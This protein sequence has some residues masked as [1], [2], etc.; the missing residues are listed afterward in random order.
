MELFEKRGVMVHING[1]KLRLDKSDI[2][3]WQLNLQ[4]SLAPEDVHSCHEA[5]ISNYQQI[6]ARQN[7]VDEIAMNLNVS[8][9]IIEFFGLSDHKAPTVRLGKCVISDMKMKHDTGL[10]ILEL[11]AEAE[12]TGVLHD[13]V[14]DYAFNP[15]HDVLVNL[16]QED[17]DLLC[18]YRRRPSSDA[19]LVAAVGDGS[20]EQ[21]G[22]GDGAGIVAAEVHKRVTADPGQL[23]A[24]KGDGVA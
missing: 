20:G 18:N 6:E 11:K 17:R 7:G 4:F 10:T 12:C 24:A 14:K 5:I 13:F 15:T 8:E 1:G 21:L 16:S 9:Q 23:G 3:R 2:R 22:A 19:T